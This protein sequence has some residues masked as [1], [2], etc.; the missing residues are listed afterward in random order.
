MSRFHHIGRHAIGHKDLQNNLVIMIDEGDT[1][2]HPEWQRNFFKKALDFLSALFAGKNL[3]LIFTANAPFITSDLPKSNVVFI[4]KKQDGSAIIHDKEN[5]QSETFG[6]NIHTLY[7]NSFYM[8][9]AL[10]GEFAKNK[11]DKIITFLNNKK[12]KKTKEEYRKTI[13][14]IGEPL[15]RRKLESMWDEK[16]DL[17]DELQTLKRRIL[18]IEREKKEKKQNRGKSKK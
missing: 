1:G 17:E 16:F 11:I 10:I 14:I 15:I 6:S 12:E 9:G 2:Y 5:S 18:E 13:E 4:E 3:Q 7:S 8:E